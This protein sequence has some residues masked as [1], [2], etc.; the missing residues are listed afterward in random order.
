MKSSGGR[1]SSTF[2][3]FLRRT[4]DGLLTRVL[5]AEP[6]AG[7][8]IAER[9][10][11]DRLAL[12]GRHRF[13]H[14]QLAFDLTE[15]AGGTTHLRATTHAE[16]PGVRGRIYRALVIGTRL[17][18]VATTRI[19]RAIRRCAESIAAAVPAAVD[20]GMTSSAPLLTVED[21]FLIGGRGLLVV[22]AVDLPDLGFRTFSTEARIQRPDRTE[23]TTVVR[24]S[25]ST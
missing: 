5:G 13:A 7:F 21:H 16:F 9:A 2:A 12:V 23:V 8:E 18:V 1:S 24:S 25:S 10:S 6:R 17:H 14:Y 3:A 15:A 19:L 11:P 20:E 22:P 4:E